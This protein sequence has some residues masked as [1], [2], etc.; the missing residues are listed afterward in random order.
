MENKYGARLV[1]VPGN[2]E[3]GE[4]GSPDMIGIDRDEYNP[5]RWQA[6]AK[7]R[8]ERL[9]EQKEARNETI[10]KWKKRGAITLIALAAGGVLTWSGIREYRTGEALRA[11]LEQQRKAEE[12]LE[13]ERKAA[14]E[15]EMAEYADIYRQLDE[16]EAE[17]D[18]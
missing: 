10:Y 13:R 12:Q 17:T 15:A 9:A 14:Q 4:N 11:E 8:N 7:A 5:E 6:E 2:G 16:M 18:E 1:N 3:T